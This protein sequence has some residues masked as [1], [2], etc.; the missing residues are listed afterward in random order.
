MRAYAF[1][2]LAFCRWLLSEGVELA[3][4]TTDVLL[5]FLAACRT[6]VLPG[7]AADVFSIRDGRNVGYA[8]A[9]VNRQ[10]G[11]DLGA[12]RLPPTQHPVTL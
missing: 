1:D 10:V 12:V 4:V 6:T 9:T 8:P 11:G 5:R 2:L 3:A 7:Q